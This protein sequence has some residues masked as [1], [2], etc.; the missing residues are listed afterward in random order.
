MWFERPH[1]FS[2][3]LD[4]RH[5]AK[6]P[7][8]SSMLSLSRWAVSLSIKKVELKYTTPISCWETSVWPQKPQE[9]GRAS[10]SVAVLNLTMWFLAIWNWFVGGIWKCLKPHATNSRECYKQQSMGYSSENLKDQKA[11]RN[12]KSR[13]PATEIS[14]GS[15]DSLGS[16]SRARLG[17]KVMD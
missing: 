14:E 2:L 8:A 12:V 16:W 17:S 15:K 7:H 1:L 3:F 6:S 13:C 10:W 9:I 11:Q 5:P 4:W